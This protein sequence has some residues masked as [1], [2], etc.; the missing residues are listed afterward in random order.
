MSKVDHIV[1]NGIGK[2]PYGQNAGIAGQRTIYWKLFSD[3]DET[4]R[5]MTYKIVVCGDC[6]FTSEEYKN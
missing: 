3:Y 4:A 2:L 6:Y 5:V 1:P